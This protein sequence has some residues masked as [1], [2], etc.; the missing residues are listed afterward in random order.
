MRFFETRDKR[1][2]HIK[3]IPFRLMTER[4]RGRDRVL[5]FS[6]ISVIKYRQIERINNLQQI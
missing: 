3:K 4:N 5:F 6:G 1:V 2:A